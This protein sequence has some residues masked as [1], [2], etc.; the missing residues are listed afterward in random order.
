M[1]R[2]LMYMGISA[3][4][5]SCVSDIEE[6]TPDTSSVEPITAYIDVQ[7]R[8]TLG[9]DTG[10]GRKVLWSSGDRIY[11]S[12][13]SRSLN[14]GV[15]STT[16][17]GS[18]KATFSLDDQNKQIDYVT[19]ILAGYPAE[20]MSIGSPDPHRPIYFTIPSVQKY[21]GGSF[22]D[23]IMPM[24]SELSFEPLLSFRN[25]ASVLSIEVKT[26]L[27]GLSVSSITISA[28]KPL[29]NECSYIP[30]DDTYVFEEYLS[31]CDKVCLIADDPVG[32]GKEPVPFNIIVP[33]QLYTSMSITVGFDNGKEQV[34]NMKEGKEIDVKRSTI[35]SIP[36]E[37]NKLQ[38]T[39]K[40]EVVLAQRGTDY[41]SLSIR[42]SIRNAD[43]YFCGVEFRDSFFRQIE[44]GNLIKNIRYGIPYTENLTYSGSIKYLQEDFKE[45]IFEPGGRYVFWV[46]PYNS[47]GYYTEDDIFYIELETLAYT[48]GGKAVVS[49]D[50][51]VTDY[52][53]VAINVSSA[54]AKKIYCALFY[55][56]EVA[57]LTVQEKTELLL[58]PGGAATVIDQ[59]V[60]TYSR[61]FIKPGSDL[62]FLA[63]AIDNNNR[64]G[65]LMELSVSTVA[66]P[67]SNLNVVIDKDL[68]K[69]RETSTIEWT[70]KGGNAL[71]YRYIFKET[72]SHLWSS[73]LEGSLMKAQETMF[74]DPGLYYITTVTQGS[75]IFSD[76]EPGTEYILIV[77]AVDQ[78]GYSSV[79]DSWK[80]IY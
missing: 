31:S 80:F 58:T 26:E 61:K 72:D 44:S 53:G 57:S 35:L 50:D 73:V 62:T 28:D 25:I 48:S 64:Y 78:E 75:A 71:K 68:E 37:V 23:G 16:D 41:E 7:T 14:K 13:G 4:L 42:M 10:T 22:D 12:S 59:K 30:A 69:L 66:I 11:V 9:D 32:I 51:I 74:L 29:S 40:P 63:L 70:S 43:S 8:T 47:L 60:A 33:H 27:E 19:G 6:N 2:F 34:F 17:G 55:D 3:V 21:V 65:E 15:F 45:Y 1:N 79:A 67:Y 38:N 36:L 5:C 46:V 77:V 76:L 20:S 49:A 54:E 39:I 56:Y 24:V 52:T 18:D